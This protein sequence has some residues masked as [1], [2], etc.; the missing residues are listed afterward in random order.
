MGDTHRGGS[1]VDMLTAGTAGTVGIDP[2]ILLIDLHIQILFYVRHHITRHK[3][4]LSLPCR[5]EWGYPHQAMYPTLGLEITKR[6][7]TIDL[8]RYGL[9]PCLVT[10]QEIQYLGLVLHLIRPPAIHPVKHAAPV[11][12]FGSACPCVETQNGITFVVFSGKQSTHTQLLQ[13]SLKFLKHLPNLRDQGFIILLVSHLDQHLD[14][15]ILLL[16]AS[17]KLH[18]ILQVLGLLHQFRRTVGIVPEPRFL[19]G[20]V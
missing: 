5:I 14:I 1:F 2:Q 3:G 11:T 13:L 7:L 19:H 20:F 8:D 18:G 6:I 15:L 12:R 16:Q 4:S 10:V 17:I 9:D